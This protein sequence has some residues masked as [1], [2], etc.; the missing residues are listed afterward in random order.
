ME[1]GGVFIICKMKKKIEVIDLFCGIGGLTNGLKKAGLNISKGYDINP[2]FKYGYEKNNKAKFICQDIREIK[3]QEI[4]DKKSKI[5]ILV[6]CAPCQPFSIYTTKYKYNK[7]NNS[8]WN[9]LN[10]FLRVIEESKPQIISFENV[11]NLKN[12]K[13]FEGFI[14]SLK[15]M[16]YEISYK[17]VN[18]I[19]YGIPQSRKRIV[20]LASKYGDIKLVNT[21]SKKPK[22]LGDILSKQKLEKIDSGERSKKDFLHTSPKLSELNIKRIKK[23]IPWGTWMDWD[24]KL[25]LECHKKLSG[26]SYTG[27]YGR[28]DYDKPSPTLTT[29]FY[30][31]GTG[32]FGHPE[33]NR[34]ISIREGALIQTFP[35]K[36]KFCKK[37]D[38]RITKL[39]LAIGNAVPPKLGL[40]IGKSI[41]KHLKKYNYGR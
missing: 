6:G 21:I 26:K 2:Y 9:L 7:D 22:T 23:S 4:F 5:K 24:E 15:K 37:E 34:A 30:S 1:V 32:R 19:E 27:V 14:E 17:I 35:K 10:E 3:G 25:R 11:P 33:E 20:L 28:M 12:K 16:K 39:G 40:Y 13:I 8:S 29:K 31:Y 36:Y 18:C 38:F 41:K